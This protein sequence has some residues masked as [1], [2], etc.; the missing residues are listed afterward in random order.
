MKYD[1]IFLE[2]L[3]KELD[4]CCAESFYNTYTNAKG[5]K[6][7]GGG[8][9]HVKKHLTSSYDHVK[10]REYRFP[11]IANG[12]EFSSAMEAAGYRIVRAK[13]YRNQMCSV[14]TKAP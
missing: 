7:I 8:E 12:W 6:V 4:R 14:V 2:R 3:R 11:G 13:N 9:A 1:P 5:E 10:G